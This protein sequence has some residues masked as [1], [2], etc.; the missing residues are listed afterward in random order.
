MQPSIPL[1]VAIATLQKLSHCHFLIH[2]L[3]KMHKHDLICL[4]DRSMGMLQHKL[5]DSFLLVDDT[6]LPIDEK[7]KLN[8]VYLHILSGT[9][10][11]PCMT[12]RMTGKYSGYVV[13]KN[14][15]C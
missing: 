2:Q 14:W 6:P 5:F 8:E 7:S 11:L 12:C 9:Y 4:T 13:L 10:L 3:P 15:E 1:M